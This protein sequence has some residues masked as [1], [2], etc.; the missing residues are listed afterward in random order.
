MSKTI[1]EAIEDPLDVFSSSLH[2][3]FDH[4][5]PANGDPLQLFTYSPP[6]RSNQLELICRIPPQQVNVSLTIL[7]LSRVG[8]A[9]REG[10]EGGEFDDLIKGGREREGQYRIR[11]GQ[12]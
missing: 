4:V 9:I 2:S 11:G 8:W 1:D 5:V 6:T 7:A 3:L 12:L 10:E